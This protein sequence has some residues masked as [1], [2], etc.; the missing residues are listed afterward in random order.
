[1]YSIISMYYL[2]LN[3]LINS[4]DSKCNISIIIINGFFPNRCL[5][6]NSCKYDA[7]RLLCVPQRAL[8]DIFAF[9]HI[10]YIVYRHLSVGSTICTE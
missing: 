5:H 7:S 1:M 6:M 3:V 10:F 2:N 9:F 4:K 8:C